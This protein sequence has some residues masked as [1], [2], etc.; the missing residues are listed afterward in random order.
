VID[1]RFVGGVS[2]RL[3]EQ[4]VD[5]RSEYLGWDWDN[6][7]K[8]LG[9][10]LGEMFSQLLEHPAFDSEAGARPL[11]VIIRERP[12][13]DT[14]SF[15]IRMLGATR[16]HVRAL[17]ASTLGYLKE[18]RGIGPMVGELRLALTMRPGDIRDVEGTYFSHY[19]CI[20]DALS[21]IRTPDPAVLS[22]L[23]DLFNTA[24]DMGIKRRAQ[25][26]LAQ[27]EQLSS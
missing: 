8:H 25:R 7:A 9:L 21:E 19:A 26:A 6:S 5:Q 18:R 3:K 16:N 4:V 10:T 17:A 14:C 22:I 27:L 20:I 2:S 15:L 11:F 13:D 12:G 24:Q 1:D 23:R